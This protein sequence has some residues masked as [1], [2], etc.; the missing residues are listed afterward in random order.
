M[1][2]EKLVQD[3][4]NKAL[5]L[6]VEKTD[7]QNEVWELKASPMKNVTFDMAIRFI[8]SK[9]EDGIACYSQCDESD[10]LENFYSMTRA[11]ND[12]KNHAN[13]LANHSCQWT[14]MYGDGRDLSCVCDICGA[15]ET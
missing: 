13:M 12:L 14:D 7:L 6:S 8:R 2:S 1:K 10:V 3:L 9:L 4:L 15:M 11:V 5:Q